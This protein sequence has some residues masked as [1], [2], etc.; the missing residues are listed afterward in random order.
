VGRHLGAPALAI[1][2]YD[3]NSTVLLVNTSVDRIRVKVPLMCFGIRLSNKDYSGY[4][5]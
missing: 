2:S 5:E 4:G 3:L 1:Y